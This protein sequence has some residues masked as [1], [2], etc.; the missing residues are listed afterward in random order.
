MKRLK[1]RFRLLPILSVFID[2]SGA[3]YAACQ[4]NNCLSLREQCV[5]SGGQLCELN[6]YRCLRTFGCPPP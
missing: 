5:S 2:T 1:F 3:A 6:Y 4:P